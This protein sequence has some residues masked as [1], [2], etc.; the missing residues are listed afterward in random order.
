[1]HSVARAHET[2]ANQALASASVGFGDDTDVHL[3]AAPAI[4]DAATAVGATT[5]A[6]AMAETAYRNSVFT[7]A[8]DRRG[9]T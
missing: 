5:N 4:P 7:R 3:A 1:M 8:G 9:V 2:P 6:A